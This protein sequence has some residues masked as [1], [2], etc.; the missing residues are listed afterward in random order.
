MIKLMNAAEGHKGNPIY[1]NPYH[2]TAVY[3]V[4]FN[5]GSLRTIIY[6]GPTGITWEVEEGL[7]TVIKLIEKERNK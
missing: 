3:P 6:G 4:A 7:E 1:I 5:E 2:I